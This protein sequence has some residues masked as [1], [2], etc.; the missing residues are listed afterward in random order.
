MGSLGYSISTAKFDAEFVSEEI[1]G[2]FKEACSFPDTH[3]KHHFQYAEIVWLD[4]DNQD[5]KGRRL[6]WWW[7]WWRKRDVKKREEERS[8]AL[9]S[10]A[11]EVLHVTRDR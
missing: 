6:W 8:K 3:P 4:E 9:R 10:K 1:G 11:K 5:I 7:R 2:I